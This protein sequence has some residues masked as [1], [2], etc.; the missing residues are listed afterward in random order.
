[1]AP[2]VFI[3]CSRFSFVDQIMSG[4]KLYETRTRDTLPR[5]LGDRILIAETGHGK[6]IIRAVATVHLYPARLRLR[7]ARQHQEEGAVRTDRRQSSRSV[8]ASGRLVP[9]R[10]SVGRT[11]RKISLLTMLR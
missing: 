9:P 5:F 8:Q 1:M 10:S 6:P 3:N 2:V 7:L 11:R 4:M